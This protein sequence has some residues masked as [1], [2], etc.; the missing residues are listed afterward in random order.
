M[1]RLVFLPDTKRLMTAA[2]DGEIKL[3]DVEKRQELHVPK[4]AGWLFGIRAISPDGKRLA[5]G[6][7]DKTIMLSNVT[8]P[9]I[10]VCQWAMLKGHTETVTML[11][12]S[13]DGKTLASGGADRTIRLW[14]LRVCRELATLAGHRNVVTAATFSP[15]GK[16]LATGSRD[17]AVILWRGATDDEV[18]AERS[19]PRFPFDLFPSF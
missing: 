13:P 5:V 15:D 6:N 17:G 3:W 9:N 18:A 14:D 7:E 19:E 10:G 11:V 2:S 4:T 1:N 16:T 8:A 12:F